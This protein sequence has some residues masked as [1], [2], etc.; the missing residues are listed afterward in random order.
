MATNGE[1][2]RQ[3]LEQNRGKVSK[4]R[5]LQIHENLLKKIDALNA[6]DE[7]ETAD[8][9]QGLLEALDVM[10]AYI[11]EQYGETPTPETPEPVELDHSSL[12]SEPSTDVPVLDDTE[13]KKRFQNLLK[14][15]KF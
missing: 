5:I 13:K 3:W 9:H 12:A 1:S 10:E 8:E 2:A 15:G 6:A 14:T 7:A 11:E 4:E